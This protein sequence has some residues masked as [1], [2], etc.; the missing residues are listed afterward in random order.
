MKKFPSPQLLTF[1]GAQVV[2]GAICWLIPFG[3]IEGIREFFVPLDRNLEAFR[4]MFWNASDPV[5]GK[6][7]LLAWWVLFVP[8]GLAWAARFTGGFRLSPVALRQGESFLL[9]GIALGCGGILAFGYL[10]AFATYPTTLASGVRGRADVLPALVS[11]VLTG[12][13]WLAACSFLFVTALA[14]F[15]ACGRALVLQ[16]FSRG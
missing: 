2:F 3:A 9:T 12:S 13:M 15:I 4:T 16:I 6:V 8:W 5:A 10:N 1:M 7:L 11:N 14:T